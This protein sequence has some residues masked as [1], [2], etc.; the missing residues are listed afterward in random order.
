MSI[1]TFASETIKTWIMK[2]NVFLIIALIITYSV[3]ASQ[4]RYRAYFP[5]FYPQ[6]VVKAKMLERNI[7]HQNDFESFYSYTFQVLDDFGQGLADTLVLLPADTTASYDDLPT[8]NSQFMYLNMQSDYYIGFNSDSTNNYFYNMR[9]FKI[10]NNN[11]KVGYGPFTRFDDF[12][13]RIDILN[14]GLPI[15]IDMSVKRF[16]RKL[17][18][19]L[20]KYKVDL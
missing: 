1:H 12:L 15:K 6:H 19:K 3:Q 8:P 7:Y 4:W 9:Y 18:R 17:K 5:H 16:E 14:L 20:K 13:D 10:D 2:R 11:N